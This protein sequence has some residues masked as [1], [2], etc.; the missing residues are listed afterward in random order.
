[1]YV[2]LSLYVFT[3]GTHLSCLLHRAL[4]PVEPPWRL[5]WC[6]C[7][8]KGT[9]T[10]RLPPTT[11]PGAR[12]R[13]AEHSH[14]RVLRGVAASSL[15][16]VI[17]VLG[18]AVLVRPSLWQACIVHPWSNWVAEGESEELQGFP[19]ASRLGFVPPPMRGI[20]SVTCRA[21]R[22][23]FFQV[24]SARACTCVHMFTYARTHSHIYEHVHT[25]AGESDT[26]THINIHTHAHT[27]AHTH[28]IAHLH[29]HTPP[30]THTCTYTHTHTHSIYTFID[31]HIYIF[32]TLP[33]SLAPS[34]SLFLT[35][36][37]SLPRFLPLSPACI[38]LS[39]SLSLSFSRHL[40]DALKVMPCI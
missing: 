24:G 13:R 26:R 7:S 36:S 14:G 25:H 28:S 17:A 19:K 27:R 16:L 12:I 39:L 5:A 21:Q 35:F 29:T 18:N 34:L 38:A 8:T 11:R 31:M 4:A 23:F 33:R 37:L 2:C 6:P 20:I 22:V 9:Q 30:L 10:R 40:F 3:Q 15:L 1:M 32:H